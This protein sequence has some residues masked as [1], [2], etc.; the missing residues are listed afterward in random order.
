MG[1]NSGAYKILLVAHLVTVIVGFGSLFF[2]SLY[3]AQARARR[4]REGSAVVDS[5]HGVAHW[6]EGFLY[7]VPVLG[8]L[9]VLVSDDVWGFSDAWISLSFVLYIAMMAVL[10][11]GHLPALRRMNAL[12]GDASGAA[13]SSAGPPPQVAE[14]ASQ[15]R[16]V[17]IT[18]AVLDCLMVLVVVLM[19]WKPGS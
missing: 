7:A 17:A 2:G 9:L 12:M 11:G 4:G 10:H 6:A 1:I 15:E 18:T 13:E 5:H 16:R 3:G 19:V 8:I 14:L